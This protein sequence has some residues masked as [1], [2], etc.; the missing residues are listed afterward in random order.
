MNIARWL[1]SSNHWLVLVNVVLAT[2]GTLYSAYGSLHQKLLKRLAQSII[3]GI[4]GGIIGAVGIVVVGLPLALL[5]WLASPSPGAVVPAAQAVVP[6]GLTVGTS[7]GFLIGL[8]SNRVPRVSSTFFFSKNFY[9][10]LVEVVL[11]I[12]TVLASNTD[13]LANV[14]SYSN[15]LV[16][17]LFGIMY[18]NGNIPWKKL[19]LCVIGVFLLDVL[20][21]K[22]I[23][24]PWL[25]FWNDW[26]VDK[27]FFFIWGFLLG[28]LFNQTPHA[29]A[30]FQNASWKR[31]FFLFSIGWVV[32]I[33]LSALSVVLAQG[34]ATT[35]FGTTVGLLIGFGSGEGNKLLRRLKPRIRSS[36]HL[37]LF[38]PSGDSWKRL[39][40]AFLIAFMYAFSALFLFVIDAIMNK[41]I[42]TSFFAKDHVVLVFIGMIIVILVLAALIGL[43]T[44]SLYTLGYVLTSNIEN[45]TEPQMVRAGVVFA[46]IGILVAGITSLLS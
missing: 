37:G 17:F 39:W 31:S 14:F 3:F 45:L 15:V 36:T 4:V 2:L 38:T 8:A 6:L 20:I 22:L 24:A 21:L 7:M 32:A 30:T 19:C 18:D 46:I 41:T 13:L 40:H 5:Y 10:L 28:S 33:A 1:T 34:F 42:L 9:F 16:G 27:L 29:S 43:I 23:N 25:H 35:V 44:G 11:I 26:L 12:A